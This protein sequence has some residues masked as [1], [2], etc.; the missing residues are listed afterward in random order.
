MSKTDKTSPYWVRV[1]EEPGITCIPVHQHADGVCDLPEHPTEMGRRWGAESCYWA[2]SK[3]FWYDR[4][5]PCGCPMCTGAHWRRAERRA[6]RHEAS[7]V[8][9]DALAVHRAGG[10]DAM[11]DYDAY[12]A[13][14]PCYW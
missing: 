1:T 5:N 10:T 9:R 13:P 3:A 8:C 4:G 12:V 2:E 14:Q 6:D 11:Q 7:R